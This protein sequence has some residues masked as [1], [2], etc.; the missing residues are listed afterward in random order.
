[1]FQF[2]LAILVVINLSISINHA[3]KNKSITGT[4]MITNT[5]TK[6]SNTGVCYNSFTVKKSNSNYI[7]VTLKSIISLQIIIIITRVL[8]LKILAKTIN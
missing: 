3:S 8:N 5:P 4:I 1:M 7:T 2:V 6:F